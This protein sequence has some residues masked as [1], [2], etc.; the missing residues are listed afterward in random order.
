MASSTAHTILITTNSGSPRPI[1]EAAAD[2]ALT[3][4]ELLVWSSDDQLGPHATAGGNAL[5]MFC[6]EDP[7]N[8][9]TAAAAIDTDYAS[10]ELARYVIAQP[11]D[12]VNAFLADGQT[13]AKGDA[14]ESDGA[15][16]LKAHSAK[17]INEGGS[18]SHTLYYDAVVAYAAEDKAASGARARIKVFAA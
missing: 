12:V 2:A 16:A 8:G 5:P 18:A 17:T 14:L 4:G 6:V 9:D 11:G 15:G 10:G 1:F 7:Y 3:P 13:V